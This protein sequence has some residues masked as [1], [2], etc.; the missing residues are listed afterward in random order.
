SVHLHYSE[1]CCGV[2][3]IDDLT[4]VGSTIGLPD[5]SFDILFVGAHGFYSSGC[6]AFV[7]TGCTDDYDASK[8]CT[9]RRYSDQSLSTSQQQQQQ[10]PHLRPGVVV[11]RRHLSHTGVSSSRNGTLRR[12]GSHGPKPPPPVR[13]TPSM[14]STKSIPATMNS[15]VSMSGLNHSASTISLVN[16]ASSLASTASLA[17]SVSSLCASSINGSTITAGSTAEHSPGHI[18][19]SENSANGSFLQRTDSESSTP[20]GSLENLPP[21]PAFLLEDGPGEGGAICPDPDLTTPEGV[22]FFGDCTLGPPAPI[23]DEGLKQ[24]QTSVHDAVKTLQDNKHQPISPLTQRKSLQPEPNNKLVEE[25]RV[26]L[27]DARTSIMSTLNAKLAQKIQ[28]TNQQQLQQMPQSPLKPQPPLRAREGSQSPRMG[29]AR[30]GSL[31]E[32][33]H[34]GSPHHQSSHHRPVQSMIISRGSEENIYGMNPL[35]QQLQQQHQYQQSLP[36]SIYQQQYSTFSQPNFQALQMQ[37][38]LIYEDTQSIYQSGGGMIRSESQQHVK[39]CGPP[40]VSK[41]PNQQAFL[42]SL[43]ETLSK[44]QSDNVGSPGSPRTRSKR[45]HS[46]GSVVHPTMSLPSGQ[47]LHRSGSNAAD[48]AS[49]VRNWISGKTYNVDPSTVKDS[50]MEQIRREQS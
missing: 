4:S 50:L 31:Q 42:Q 5:G 11:L 18:S 26:S 2:G 24:R 10:L 43:N 45:G 20:V 48:K 34:L 38:Q 35:Q 25:R 39:Q 30:L 1:L 36:H 37:P 32:G 44:R 29:R 46:E 23:I 21:P 3:G 27:G 41:K 8:Y 17:S 47:T 13:R 28:Q 40:P 19:S 22:R 7:E 9:L 14:T 12:S 49:R 16:H 33:V 15:P 6:K